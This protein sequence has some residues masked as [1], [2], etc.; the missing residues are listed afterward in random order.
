MFIKGKISKL[1]TMKI[2]NFYCARDS[3]KIQATEWEK[4]FKNYISNKQ[5]MFRI[6]FKSP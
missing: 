6:Y 3:V 1:D 2:K 5:I 4:I